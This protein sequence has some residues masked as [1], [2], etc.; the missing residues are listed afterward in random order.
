MHI[1]LR[2]VAYIPTQ[3]T[4]F[5]VIVTDRSEFQKV[6]IQCNY[7]IEALSPAAAELHALC[8]YLSRYSIAEQEYLINTGLVTP[9]VLTDVDKDGLT[10]PYV[11]R[12]F[13]GLARIAF[14]LSVVLLMCA[15]LWLMIAGL[16]QAFD[17]LNAAINPVKSG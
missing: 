2:K 1:P 4:W 9:S 12:R 11:E 3:R 16:S 10:V 5:S 15:A 14:L 8:R 7:H 17:I 6:P 13:S